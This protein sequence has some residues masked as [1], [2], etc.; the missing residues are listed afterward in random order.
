MQYAALAAI[1]ANPGVDATRLSDLIAF[2]RSTL[3]DV[4][5]RLESKGWVRRTPAPLDRR[6]KVITLSSEGAAQLQR[7]RPAVE[8]VQERLLAPLEAAERPVLMRLL[9]ALAGLDTER[10]PAPR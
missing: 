1:G 9:S 3:G 7:V 4:L 6:Q 8:R 2:D 10:G 5:E